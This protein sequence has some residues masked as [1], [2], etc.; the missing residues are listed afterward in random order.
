MWHM[1]CDMFHFI[2]CGRWTFTQLL[3]SPGLLIIW[4]VVNSRGNTRLHL[5]WTIFYGFFVLFCFILFC[6]GLKQTLYAVHWVCYVTIP[7]LFMF[8]SCTIELDCNEVL[9][10]YR[11]CEC[12]LCSMD[13]V[14][15]WP[16]F[17]HWPPKYTKLHNVYWSEQTMYWALCIVLCILCIAR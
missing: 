10:H 2:Y 16:F 1:T 11:E 4:H 12:Q 8:T 9:S 17:V 3:S 5:N 15:S 13:R 6:Y 7:Q 14:F